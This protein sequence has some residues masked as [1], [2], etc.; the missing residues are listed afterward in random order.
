LSKWLGNGPRHQRRVTALLAE[1]GTTLAPGKPT[2]QF[3]DDTLTTNFCPFR[4]ASVAELHRK[5]ESDRFSERL[6]SDLLR[7]FVP[8]M[9]IGNG[10][11]SARRFITPLAAVGFRERRRPSKSSPRRAQWPASKGSSLLRRGVSDELNEAPSLARLQ[12]HKRQRR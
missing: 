7:S 5:A 1:I 3:I 6:W 2:A 8:A 10:R 12:R 11:E 4:S 9:L